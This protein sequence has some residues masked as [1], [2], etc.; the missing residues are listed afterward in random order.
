M[1]G[2]LG[3]SLL[4]ALMER[5][6]NRGASAIVTF[7]MALFVSPAAAGAYAFGVLALTF[8]QGVG[9]AV[10]RQIGV[11]AW[12]YEGGGAQLRRLSRIIAW[13]GG[14]FVLGA[15]TLAWALGLYGFGPFLLL[16][17]FAAVAVIQGLFAPA[18]T[19][20]QYHGR[21]SRLTRV[22]SIGGVLS[23]VVAV[24]LLPF[25]GIASA[26]L[27]TVV[28]ETVFAVW[29]GRGARVP[30][31]DR[32]RADV[33]RGFYVPTAVSNLFGWFAGQSDRLLVTIL[34]GAGPLGLL[35]LALAVSRTATDAV[36]S[37]I[38][39][40]L[41]SRLAAAGSDEERS[42][43]FTHVVARAMAIAAALQVFV[44]VLSFW[45]LPLLLHSEWDPAL[46]VVPLLAVY[47]V[48]AAA[49]YSASAA[50]IDAGRAKDLRVVNV[51]SLLFAAVEGVVLSFSLPLGAGVSAVGTLVLTWMQLLLVRQELP[52]AARNRVLL[53]SVAASLFGVV[54][55]ALSSLLGG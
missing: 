48:P 26:V 18:I 25:G 51:V 22:Q 55:Y 53:A 21:W 9:E 36:L 20:A 3:G 30:T 8:A 42:R 50:M 23:L 6:V 15:I 38:L 7:A 27:Q 41:R 35:S 44:T 34:A 17:P 32:G 4:L 10:L 24:P 43:S 45:P 54:V 29:A 11:A 14:A 47:G 1:R 12:R 37:G 19:L 5:L 49:A 46:H 28:S 16:T 31:P 33:L 39:N 13:S 52:R 2:I 40:L